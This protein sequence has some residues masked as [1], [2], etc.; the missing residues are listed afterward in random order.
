MREERMDWKQAR[1]LVR[2]LILLA[3][4]LLWLA[5]CMWNGNSPLLQES[6]TK[7]D[8]L[9]APAI[10]R[11]FWSTN[12]A[13]VGQEVIL[14]AEINGAPN[15]TWVKFDIYEV[16]DFDPLRGEAEG[17]GDEHVATVYGRVSSGRATASWRIVDM[18]DGWKGIWNPPEYKF[19]AS[20]PTFPS[21]RPVKSDFLQ[22]FYRLNLSGSQSYSLTG[23]Y[24]PAIGGKVVTIRPD[25][26]A[27]VAV[28]VDAE[29]LGSL[30]ELL[31][32]KATL[33][34]RIR[35][36]V[37]LQIEGQ[38]DYEGSV[39]LVKIPVRFGTPLYGSFEILLALDVKANAHLKGRIVISLNDA[40]VSIT[41]NGQFLPNPKLRW[42]PYSSVDYT[43]NPELETME[44]SVTIRP[45]VEIVVEGGI[46]AAFAALEFGLNLN[47]SIAFG[48]ELSLYYSAGVPYYATHLVVDAG[49]RAAVGI[50][51]GVLNAQKSFVFWEGELARTQLQEQPISDFSLTVTPMSNTVMRPTSGTVTTSI[52]VRA[53]RTA[54]STG[55][56]NFTV[57]GLPTGVT[58]SPASWSWRLGDQRHTLTFSIGS[59]A[60]VGTHTIRIRGTGG[61]VTREVTYALVVITGVG[62]LRVVIEPAEARSAGAQWR[63]TSG[64][65]TGWKNSGVTVSNLPVGTYTVTFKDI[66]GWTRPADVSVT[67]TANQT[68]TIS[69]SYTRQTQQVAAQI[70]N[71]GASPRQ[72]QLG[73]SVTFT[74]AIQNTGSGSWTFYGALSLRRPNRTEVHL[75]LRPITL[76]AGQQG[77]VSWTYT[78]DMAGSWDVIFGL[79]KEESQ[80]TSLGYAGWFVGYLTVSQPTKPA[81]TVI[82]PNG[83]EVWTVGSTQTIRWSSQ[84]LSPTTQI[85][86]FYWYSDK[87]QLVAGPMSPTQTSY[88]WTIPNTPIDSTRVFVGAWSGSFWEA[89]DQSDQPFRIVTAGPTGPKV[90]GV[91]PSQPKAQPNRQ[92]L[93]VL[94]SGFVPGSQ[95]ILRFG[96]SVYPIPR[97]RTTFVS[98]TEIWVYVG[99]TDPGTWTV[100]V[101]NP[102]GQSSNIFSFQ[103]IR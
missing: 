25:L 49:I 34:A 26:T 45:K 8:T 66:P 55:K 88:S 57:T 43:V 102:D 11:V 95:V 24:S 14:T 98:A 62:S 12:K 1:F 84:N 18:R 56:V 27:S 101:V 92:W 86:V 73:Q 28:S 52:T 40:R 94:G 60:P 72:V 103:V 4:P 38:W 75:P 37:S 39:Q 42:S 16:D 67:I 68:A 36:A 78:P 76:G 2:L 51:A 23:T 99:L 5:G 79:W 10:T 87:W 63:L 71:Y 59:N 90:T 32:G 85:Y 19:T 93:G 97:D 100:Q 41:G 9:A 3:I 69:R 30:T 91:S 70:V 83:G 61:G 47:G 6:E 54:G 58:V 21:V 48:P 44:G 29:A 46:G 22:V 53:W 20:I 13:P 50:D 80:Q 31:A 65:D 7:L 15:G 64:P 35:G 74:M 82:S 17:G 33:S 81:I 89:S 96:G 77:N